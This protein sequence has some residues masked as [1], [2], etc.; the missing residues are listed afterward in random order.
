M[1]CDESK[2][3][4]CSPE[5]TWVAPLTRGGNCASGLRPDPG[6]TEARAAARRARPWLK[7]AR[8]F[9]SACR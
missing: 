9:G 1:F 2:E 7:P 6:G 5:W 4:V 3:G 8:G